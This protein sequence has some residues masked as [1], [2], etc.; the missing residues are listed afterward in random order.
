MK[1]DARI[2]AF[3]GVKWPINATYLSTVIEILAQAPYP[4]LC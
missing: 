3:S 4:M 2:K 1:M